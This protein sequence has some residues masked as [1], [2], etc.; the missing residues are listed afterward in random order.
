M[1]LKPIV[2]EIRIQNQVIFLDPPI[3]YARSSCMIGLVC[4]LPWLSLKL[5]LSMLDRCYLQTEEDPEF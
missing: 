3:E 5:K 4:V 2:H 1:T